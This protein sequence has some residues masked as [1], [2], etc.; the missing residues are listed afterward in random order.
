MG[1]EL[2]S[3]VPTELIVEQARQKL[4]AAWM[5]DTVL[6]LTQYRPGTPLWERPTAPLRQLPRTYRMPS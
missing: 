6:A 1:K 5:R 4:L 2:L 3:A